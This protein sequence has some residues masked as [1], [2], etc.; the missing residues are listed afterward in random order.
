M[1]QTGERILM[2]QPAAPG[3]AAGP[4]IGLDRARDVSRSAGT[5]D[6]ERA[7]LAAA[8]ET[9]RD[10]LAHLIEMTGPGEA[11]DILEFQLALIDDDDLTGPPLA[12]TETGTPAD[13]AWA[14]RMDAEIAGYEA[15]EDDYFR[16]R[17]ADLKDL[18][19]RVLDAIAGTSHDLADL[20]STAIFL[21][22]DLAPSRFL[23]IQWGPGHGLAL[24]GAS[25]TAHVAILA[26]GKGVPLI[27]GLADP[28]AADGVPALLDVGAGTLTIAPS[29]ET[30]AAFEARRRAD[31]ALSS[32]AAARVQ[33]PAITG[34]GEKVSV[35]INIAGP[36]D[37]AGLDPAICDGIGLVRTEFLF[38]D[39]RLETLPGEDEQ[40]AVYSRIL[41][42]AAGRPVTFRTLDAGG[43]KPIPGL[44]LDHESNP[45]LGVRGV[46]LSLRHENVFRTQLRALLRASARGQARIMVP[47]VTLPSE[48]FAV[49]QLLDDEAARL[50]AEGIPRGEPQL[51]MMVE[52]P[53]VALTLDL[54]LTDFASIGSNDLTQYVMAAGRDVTALAEL[55]DAASPAVIRLIAMAAAAAREVGL[56]LSLCG[57]AGGDPRVIPLLLE[58]GL[59][60]LSM[61]PAVVAR[62]KAAIRQWPGGGV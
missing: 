21:A 43:D 5:P 31:A 59:R 18:K 12:A 41:D 27:T 48:M 32:A 17:A 61:A 28:D 16:A 38:H 62:A 46:R 4:L 40:V 10:Q 7:A 37:L 51:G 1:S 52:V 22:D 24:T 23:E 15:A 2:G 8:F 58:A 45:F 36:D 54:F 26:R 34:T 42:W 3:F 60:S 44:T 57:D 50:D 56:P 47:M 25:P 14:E 35:L 49:R 11:A 53:A 29:A 33:D 39:R 55:A 6:E 9:A 30:I 20:P 13:A 19:A